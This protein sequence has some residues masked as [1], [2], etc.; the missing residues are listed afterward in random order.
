MDEIMESNSK[1]EELR[2]YSGVTGV[3]FDSRGGD[4]RCI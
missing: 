3:E 1:R 2:A 4:W